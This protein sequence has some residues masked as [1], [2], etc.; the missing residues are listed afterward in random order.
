MSDKD[1]VDICVEFLRDSG[2]AVKVSGGNVEE[3]LPKSQIEYD[4][5]PGD[6]ITVTMPNWL[7]LEKGLI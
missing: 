1:Q 5:E 3:W 6:T 2:R 7:A 4:G